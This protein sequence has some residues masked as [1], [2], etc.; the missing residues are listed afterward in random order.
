MTQPQH[1]SDRTGGAAQ[2]RGHRRLALAAAVPLAILTTATVA[3]PTSAS[4]GPRGGEGPR[5]ERLDTVDVFR[6]LTFTVPAGRDDL[7]SPQ[8]CTIDA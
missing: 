3:T 1:R 6:G 7:G 5:A 8:T 2:R 4:A